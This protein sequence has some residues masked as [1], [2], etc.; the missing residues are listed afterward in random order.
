ME[1]SSKEQADAAERHRLLSERFNEEEIRDMCLASGI[2]FDSLPGRDASEKM[3]EVIALIE[4]NREFIIHRERE[5]SL[6]IPVNVKTSELLQSHTLFFVGK[7][8]ISN[9]LLT[10][11]IIN[12][13][14]QSSEEETDNRQLTP[15]YLNTVVT[16]YL[17]ALEEL[18]HII[19]DIGGYEHQ[20]VLIHSLTENSPITATVE[21]ITEAAKLAQDYVIPWR[22]AH[23]E[24][25]AALEEQEKTET[26]AAKQAE[27]AEGYAR[28]QKE[29]REAERL[30]AEAAVKRA[31]AER[32]HLENAKLRLEL[33]RAEIQLAVEI[34]N[35]IGVH[36]SEVERAEYIQRLLPVLNL[37]T[38]SPL[39]LT[40]SGPRAL[41]AP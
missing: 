32:I 12:D 7:K 40:G 27:I 17:L 25:M 16:P 36:L 1:P 38:T 24:K 30:S 19:D 22:R 4:R 37:L 11:L 26:I 13:I 35:T 14:N 33:K 9:K 31:E 3:Q 5:D 29:R 21:G 23:A 20:D 6:D 10:T 41:P 8:I 39:E 28:T 18:Q 2:D 34:M 15:Q